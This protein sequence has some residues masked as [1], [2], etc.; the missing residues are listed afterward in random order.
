MEKYKLNNRWLAI[1]TARNSEKTIETTLDSILGQTNAPSYVMVVDDG[2]KDSTPS[3]LQKISEHSNGVLHV[4]TQP[5]MG[6]DSRRIV[7]NWNKAL[8]YAKT[9]PYA[10]Y[11][12]IS[13][14]DCIYPS[15]YA[16]FLIS[17]M[18]ENPKLVVASGSRELKVKSFVRRAPEGSGR[19][20]DNKFFNAIDGKYPPYYGYES[21]I[22]FKALQLDFDIENY[23]EITFEHMRAFGSEHH[24]VEYGP[25]M[26]CLGYHPLF[27]IFR[28]IRNILFGTEEIPARASLRMIYDYFTADR[29]F[30][31]DEYYRYY[32]EEM[33]SFVK[34]QQAKRI[35][36]FLFSFR[37]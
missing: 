32:D 20:V 15:N 17:K 35:K 8:E 19:M 24:F 27:V 11:H 36:K 9:L 33:R 23:T 1:V 37:V 2:S 14:D 18:Q 25:M 34:K 7:H 4:I 5:D 21:W 26:K 10:N 13:A 30:K 31:N 12:F 22:L 28:C 6:Y 16:E 29:R 3:I